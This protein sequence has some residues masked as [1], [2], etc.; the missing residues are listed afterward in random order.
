MKKGLA[1]LILCLFPVLSAQ[2]SL[3]SFYV[4][5]TGLNEESG[6]NRHS[7]LWENAFMDVFFDSGFIVS[8][9]PMLR[10]NEKPNVPI[11]E[12]C[13]FCVEEA[14]DAGVHYILI[15]Q[16]DFSNAMRAPDEISLYVFKV[17]DHE[18]VYERQIAGRNYGSDRDAT[19]DMKK[20]ISPLVQFV[21][22]L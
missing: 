8:N 14:I 17:I 12:A 1:V 10:L 3:I 16:L 15:A 21:R 19:E 13:G 9:Y 11:I 5:E 7:T 18:I 6:R 2:A 22:N 4:I 20:T